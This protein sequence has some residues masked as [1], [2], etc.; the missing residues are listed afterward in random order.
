MSLLASIDSIFVSILSLPSNDSR[1]IRIELL[2]SRVVAAI[3]HFSGLGEEY[4]SL[5]MA[6]FGASTGAAAALWAADLRQEKVKCVVSRGGRPDLVPEKVLR[7]ISAPTL[8]ILGGYDYEVIQLNQQAYR[9][10]GAA[11]KRFEIVPGATH[12]FEEPGEC[13]NFYS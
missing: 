3:D 7:E 4:A 10:L 9:A 5:P 12:L 2:T 1:L 6:T 11:D 13:I 8:F